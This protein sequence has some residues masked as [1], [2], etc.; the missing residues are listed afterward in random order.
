MTTLIDLYEKEREYSPSN[1][2]FYFT[3]YLIE[4]ITSDTLSSVIRTVFDSDISTERFIKNGLYIPFLHIFLLLYTQ[5]L[6]L[7]SIIIFKF[8]PAN[9]YFWFY[10][11]YKYPGL[12]RWF[13]IYKQFIR[14]T[15]SGHFAS[16]LY[17]TNP[18]F[19]SITYNVH[20]A[21]TFGYWIGKIM[22]NLQ[23]NDDRRNPEIIYPFIEYW[24]T[25]NHLCPLLLM[26][27]ELWI[28]QDHFC[29]TDLFTINDV[30][31]SFLWGYF[32]L[33][34]IYIPWRIVTKD[35]VYSV[36]SDETPIFF[37]GLFIFMMH[38]IF[39]ISNISGSL[40]QDFICKS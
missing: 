6:F 38:V 23:D 18:A 11:L 19:F 35:C 27:H 14:F 13:S 40:I 30:F 28:K 24:S 15:D 16:F 5:N 32:W 34:F 26:I 36:L 20:F 39:Y 29:N 21:I 7:S 8:Y 33:A 3:N 25:C 37:Q 10:S 2:R 1:T 12:P 22:F 4:D 9:Y 17:Y 31:Y